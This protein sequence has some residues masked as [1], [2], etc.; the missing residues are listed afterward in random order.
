MENVEVV[1]ECRFFLREILINPYLLLEL[2]KVA[3]HQAS[4]TV[5][6]SAHVTIRQVCMGCDDCS[7]S[8]AIVAKPKWEPPFLAP[9]L[10]FGGRLSANR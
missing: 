7:S 1:R 3:F 6:K 4:P 10:A 2:P 9:I 5:A 8:S